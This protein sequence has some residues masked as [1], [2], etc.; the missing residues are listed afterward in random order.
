METIHHQGYIHLLVRARLDQINLPST[1][2]FRRGSKQLC[3]TRKT[4]L[5]D[6]ESQREKPGDTGYRNEVV[7]ARMSD[8]R[9]RIVFCVEVH[10]AAIRMPDSGLK[11]GGNAVSMSNNGDALQGKEVANSVVRKDLVIGQLWRSMNLQCL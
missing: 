5:L 8:V 7:S 6:G 2:F 3:L 10:I 1:V 11:S 4:E 9:Q